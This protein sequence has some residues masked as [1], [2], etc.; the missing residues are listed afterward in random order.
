MLG[1]PRFD[2]GS[3]QLRAA[4]MECRP[5]IKS[6]YATVGGDDAVCLQK[7]SS[8]K[9]HTLDAAIDDQVGEDRGAALLMKKHGLLAKGIAQTQCLIDLI[10]VERGRL[11]G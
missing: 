3:K 11:G 9:R 8:E 6:G 4:A 7:A 10:A 2:L 5:L 1:L